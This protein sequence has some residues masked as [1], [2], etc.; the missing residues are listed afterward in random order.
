MVK[1]IP[2]VLFNPL[3]EKKFT[4]GF[5]R[6]AMMV[7]NIKGTIMCRAIYIKK[8]KPRMPRNTWAYLEY[9][10]RMLSELLFMIAS[11][12]LG[13]QSFSLSNIRH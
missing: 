13:I 5:S 3:R 7:A 10:E 12:S 8:K 9:T 4:T 6:K 2:R 11:F 1:K